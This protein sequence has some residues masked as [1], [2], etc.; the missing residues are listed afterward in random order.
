MRGEREADGTDLAPISGAEPADGTRLRNLSG[1]A[2][3]RTA[4][5]VPPFSRARRLQAWAGLLGQEGGRGTGLEAVAP[6]M[7]CV[8]LTIPQQEEQGRGRGRRGVLAG[9]L[10]EKI[11]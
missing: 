7:R 4:W 5:R 1:R 3:P 6:K 2:R 10:Q 9:P 8:P 11:W